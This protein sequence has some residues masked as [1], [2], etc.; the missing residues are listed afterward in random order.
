MPRQTSAGQNGRSNGRR[1]D[2]VAQEAGALSP[3]FLAEPL[4]GSGL[5]SERARECAWLRVLDCT[6]GRVG[7]GAPCCTPS[8]AVPALRC[9]PPISCWS[10]DPRVCRARRRRQLFGVFLL[11][12]VLG[13][14]INVV[15]AYRAVPAVPAVPCLRS[16]A[17]DPMPAPATGSRNRTPRPPTPALR[18][19]CCAGL[20]VPALHGG[21]AARDG[22]R[23][24]TVRRD[25]GLDL[26]LDT[27]RRVFHL[28]RARHPVHSARARPS[29][30]MRPSEQ[31]GDR[32]SALPSESLAPCCRLGM[33][34]CLVLG[35]FGVGGSFLCFGFATTFTEAMVARAAA[36]LLNGNV[37]ILKACA[38]R[39]L[40]LD[41]LLCLCV[42]GCMCECVCLAVCV[43]AC[44]RVSVCLPR[45][46]GG[47]THRDT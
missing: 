28:G 10:A 35:L 5:G 40:P 38:P 3:H 34:R 13:F 36:G 46:A 39:A 43:C 32:R 18:R 26:F 20:A 47:C 25:P 11:N 41:H 12:L 23:E 16:R 33:R 4:L 37:P 45:P 8:I 15:C 6:E 21:L 27:V 17:C 19:G 22:G 14:Q 31:P 24:R 30:A 42:H 2:T 7:R 44:L 1:G 29:A 9:C